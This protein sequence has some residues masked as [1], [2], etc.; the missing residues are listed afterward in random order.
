MGFEFYKKG[1]KKKLIEEVGGCPP[2]II[3]A[4]SKSRAI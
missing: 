4:E 2:K 1:I 3:G